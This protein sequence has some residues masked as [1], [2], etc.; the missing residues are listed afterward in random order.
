VYYHGEQSKD[1]MIVKQ[2]ADYEIGIWY[3]TDK[4]TGQPLIPSIW[5]WE[6]Q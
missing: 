5:K 6:R 4:L 1:T 2:H 3:F